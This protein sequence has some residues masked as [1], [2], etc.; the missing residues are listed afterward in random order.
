MAG[1]GKTI[2]EAGIRAVTP[3]PSVA[4][5]L[6]RDFPGVDASFN[7]GPKGIN[8]D[9]LAE[10]PGKEFTGQRVKFLESMNEYAKQN[11]I[12]LNVTDGISVPEG[13]KPHKTGAALDAY[14]KSI[15]ASRAKTQADVSGP[16]S[17]TADFEPGTIPAGSDTPM[18][19]GEYPG[20]LPPVE[21]LA[22]DAVVSGSR[23]ATADE[24][25]KSFTEA[26]DANKNGAS[27]YTYP[28]DE[29][30]DMG[31]YL[32]DNGKAGYAIT[33]DGD[34]VSVFK[35]P[36]SNMKGALKTLVPDAIRSGAKTL[37]AFDGFLTDSYKK[38]GFV[39][40]GRVPFDPAQAPDNWD[41]KTMGTPDVVFMGVPKRSGGLKNQ[42]QII[43]TTNADAAFRHADG[44]KFQTNR[45]FKLDIQARAIEAARG[46]NLEN[47]E[48]LRQVAYEDA[49]IALRD[50]P[51]AV[52]WYDEKITK[53]V[54]VL[55][56]IH[57]EMETDEAARF[58][59]TWALAATS[60][61]LKVDKN[62]E[63]AERAYEAYKRTGK[64]PTNIG[65]GNASDSINGAMRNF[66]NLMVEIGPEEF[67]RVMTTKMR[68]GEVKKLTGIEVKGE[69][70]NT[71]VYGAAIMGPK[72][73]NGFFANLYG[74]F[75][76][77]TMDRWFMRTWGRWTGNLVHVDK[78]KVNEKSDKL[79]ALVDMLSP[80]AKR[81][82]KKITG[83]SLAKTSTHALA[84]AIQKASADKAKR[85][86]I[87]NLDDGVTDGLAG[88]LGKAK[89]NSPHTGIGDEIRK[90]GNNL[91][92]DL[93][94]QI[95]APGGVKQ[96]DQ[97]RG[98]MNDALL[99]V[100]ESHPDITMADLQ[101]LLWYPEKRLYD[102]AK[103]N[104]DE[105]VV[106]YADDE[107][108]DYANAAIALA[109]DKGIAES[110]INKVL[111]EVDNELST[112]GRAAGIRRGDEG[113]RVSEGAN[114][115]PGVSE[116]SSAEEVRALSDVEGRPS[117]TG[118]MAVVG[119]PFAVSSL[120]ANEAEAYEPADIG[121]TYKINAEKAKTQALDDWLVK[122]TEA[123]RKLEEERQQREANQQNWLQWTMT[124]GG[125]AAKSAYNGVVVAA[126]E[127]RK[128][129]QEFD[130]FLDEIIGLDLVQSMPGPAITSYLIENIPEFDR[131]GDLGDQLIEGL[132]QFGAAMVG[133]YK[134]LRG[135]KYFSGS[136]WAAE[137]GRM[138]MAGAFADFAAFNPRD[139]RI[140]NLLQELGVHN[141]FVDWM[142]A[143]EDD[144]NFEGRLKNMMEGLAVGGLFDFTFKSMKVAKKMYVA[145]G[146][147]K[148]FLE[149]L[150]GGDLHLNDI[151]I[152]PETPGERMDAL[153][154][155]S[156]ETVEITDATQDQMD[157]YL[158]GIDPIPEKAVNINLANIEN[159]D[160]IIEAIAKT[161]EAFKLE[162]D[163]AR[164]GTM[165]MEQSA[166]LAEDMDMSVEELLA[167][168]KG[169]AFNA[170]QAIAARHILASSAKRLEELARLASS[171]QGT[172]ES[173]VA[174]RQ[175]LAVH[176]AIQQQ[177]SGMTAE[178]GRALASF[179]YSARAG[180]NLLDTK[181]I[182]DAIEASG[183]QPHLRDM[184]NKL[185]MMNG[186]Q[187]NR[188]S[189]ELVRPGMKDM[190]FEVW[191]NGLL[192]SPATHV[193]NA[194]SN[195]VTAAWQVPERYLAAG[196][197]WARGTEGAI[198]FGEG[199][200]QLY[201]MIE[202]YKDGFALAWH[203]LKTGEPSDA[204]TKIESL[205]HNAITADNVGVANVAVLGK[206]VDLL[207]EYVIRMPG[208]FLTAGD[209]LFKAVGYRMELR[210]RAY[211]LAESEGL[212]GDALT[213]RIAEILQ[214]TPSDIKA[215][216]I[217]AARYQTFTNE[218]G[219]TGKSV[220]TFASS[221]P[222]AKMVIPF[223]R[224]PTNILKYTAERT[225]LA[226]F[227][228]ETKAAIAKGGPEGDLALA[229]ITMGTMIMGA[230]AAYVQEGVI[231][232]AGPMNPNVNRLWREAGHQPYSIKVGDTYY[233]YNR[234]DPAGM[235]IGLT[236]DM[237][238][239]LKYASDTEGE[240][241]AMNG[242]MAVGLATVQNL[243]NK[244]YVSGPAQLFKVLGQAQ[245]DPEAANKSSKNYL[246][247]LA[248]SFAPGTSLQAQITRTIDP[249]L[250]EASGVVESLKRR[251]PG[252][253]DTLPPR[254]NLFG[255]P[256]ML[257]GGLG[258][259]F[260]SP[261][262]RSTIKEDA[263]YR[264]LLDN[265]VPISRASKTVMGIELNGE[266]YDAYTL[267]SAGKDLDGS[268]LPG[269][270]GKDLH[271][272]MMEAIQSDKYK[273]AT[274]GPE[275][276]RSMILM[277]I[278]R[279]YRELG[280]GT[281]MKRYPE[282]ANKVRMAQQMKV[283]KLRPL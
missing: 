88:V 19:K 29:Y 70:V 12:D 238:E 59:F 176:G 92:K 60:N 228:A 20:A 177:V 108:P 189:R 14:T 226:L 94:G 109:K 135:M 3:N 90:M 116:V 232:G 254:R 11:N 180:D 23:K 27:V 102:S 203:A 173:L 41:V 253:S 93:D 137:T 231:T 25:F 171:T 115:I 204:M 256:I 195:A 68:A 82:L 199:T 55:G 175:A 49:M 113:G 224:T 111:K 69:G 72:I 174:F 246:S 105:A 57:P 234:L 162:I 79:R 237:T 21:P 84:V 100:Q 160:D 217:D 74:N 169:E 83:S 240:V 267:F 221:T 139:P 46:Q 205:N 212:S 128:T 154:G 230:T 259:D 277:L 258:W 36:E 229:R 197:G 185:L 56:L 61:G 134:I 98:V 106:S 86:A 54:R 275:G 164:R 97:I 7:E 269:T 64:M 153:L 81:A 244:T 198:P 193:V 148:K 220:Q 184:A 281:M 1:P 181:A 210:A 120:Y 133:P 144:G 5:R 124:E 95:E 201:G 77:L 214:T 52:G 110:K 213:T 24:F 91:A 147:R 40:T 192:S 8:L 158:R 263:V 278:A 30:K 168:N 73:G 66:N 150:P 132:A 26:K 123:G 211:R 63:L 271:T 145:N 22:A 235:L 65:I 283:D 6:A 245:T 242:V 165:S 250:R 31:L 223:V 125:E 130:Q 251:T 18:P 140:A 146:E 118:L 58:A 159:V 9:G 35:H 179:R 33:K 155:K 255:D 187:V 183:G 215:A 265:E 225:P 129:G 191:I 43:A 87:S 112:D 276:S 216:A 202:G 208:R 28:K 78:V 121:N 62:F 47:P 122:K 161:A 141:D 172:P 233:S 44:L 99:R 194:V 136:S 85:L 76:Q 260:V 32:Y 75:E 218:L 107:A 249:T 103:K 274:P 101:A 264:E 163:D 186:K 247:R 243:T 16:K 268:P 236:A 178:A 10:K 188:I 151:D 182:M 206:A 67:R 15:E 119:L 156:W 248:T 272:R 45:D 114:G 17:E 239:I 167:R 143:D 142:A 51:N 157:S 241:D 48:Y 170:E 252:M 222:V 261:V 207:G 273:E 127:M 200:H 53:A 280:Q 80:E 34:L 209:E 126:K 219:K 104:L 42:E 266:E 257:E 2:F 138:T 39:E 71:E 227:G 190:F 149:I 37:D 262:Y 270:H 166:K 279:G 89:S 13:F 282:F 117:A 38:L 131:S 96:R 196:I 50:N 4:E 152:G